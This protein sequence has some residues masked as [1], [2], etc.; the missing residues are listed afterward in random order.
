M[1]FKISHRYTLETKAPSFLGA[2]H[3]NM[4]LIDILS[5]PS[6]IKRKEDLATINQK[7]IDNVPGAVNLDASDLEYLVFISPI[8]QESI[9]AKQWIDLSTIVDITELGGGKAVTYK[10]YMT[11]LDDVEIIN[12]ALKELGFINFEIDIKDI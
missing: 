3:E 10:M 4:K 8:G 1:D 7:I 11:N 2:R 9:I 12:N 6:A 5:F